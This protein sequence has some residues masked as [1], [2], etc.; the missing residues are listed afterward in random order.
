MWLDVQKGS[1]PVFQQKYITCLVSDL[2]LWNLVVGRIYDYTRMRETFGVIACSQMELCLLKVTKS[3]PCVKDPFLL[4]ESHKYCVSNVYKHN[5][6]KYLYKFKKIS[7][8]CS[9][10]Y[11]KGYMYRIRWNPTKDNFKAKSFVIQIFYII[12]LL[13]ISM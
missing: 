5:L 11:L 8:S 12:Q 3:V 10:I 4:I 7:I 2:Q 1:H 13:A 9:G 6:I